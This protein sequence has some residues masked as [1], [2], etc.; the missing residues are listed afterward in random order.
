MSGFNVL[1]TIEAETNFNLFS[2][3]REGNSIFTAFKNVPFIPIYRNYAS[4]PIAY[5]YC[6]MAAN[7]QQF[8]IYFNTKVNAIANIPNSGIVYALQGNAPIN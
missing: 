7:K 8:S 1:K 4:P 6:G 5:I 2:L 3:N